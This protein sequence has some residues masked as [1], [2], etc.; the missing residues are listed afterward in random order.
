MTQKNFFPGA[1][2]TYPNLDPTPA[3]VYIRGV[4]SD[5]ARLGRRPLWPFVPSTLYA[6]FLGNETGSVCI[7]V[8]TWD[9][10]LH[11]WGL[12]LR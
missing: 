12:L 8:L 10:S 9:A 6:V 5:Y 7:A 4:L 2:L 11:G 1:G 3:A